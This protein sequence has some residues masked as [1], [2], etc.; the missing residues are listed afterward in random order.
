MKPESPKPAPVTATDPA[1]SAPAPAV[2][3][4]AVTPPVNTPPAVVNAKKADP[5][6]PVGMPVTFVLAKGN[7]KGERRAALIV[8]KN[9]DGSVN[10]QV[11][12]DGDGNLTGDGLPQVM[13]VTNARYSEADEAGTWRPL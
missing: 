13:R 12:T 11:F 1:P 8:K 6:L 9:G 10:L 5:N 4:T 2:V 3:E 7:S